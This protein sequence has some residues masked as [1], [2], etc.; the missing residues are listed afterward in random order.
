LGAVFQEVV[1]EYGLL[2][3]IVEDY[4][5]DLRGVQAGLDIDLSEIRTHKGDF[6]DSQLAEAFEASQAIPLIAEAWRKHASDRRTLAFTP[7]VRT[8]E[9]L[10]QTVA[11]MGIA[12]EAVSGQTP[13]DARLSSWRT[14]TS[15]PR[16]LTSRPSTVCW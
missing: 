4:L 13:E 12:A 3:A 8:A 1:H 2:E 15:S 9:L 11:S 5:S 7:S 16:A 14:A 6:V 10:A